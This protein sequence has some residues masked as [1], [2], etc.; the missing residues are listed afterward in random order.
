M[1]KL[2]VIIVSF[3]TKDLIKNCIESVVKNTKG[4]GYE[5]IVVDNGST[6]DSTAE[7]KRLKSKY[8]GVDIRLFE[9]KKNLGFAKANNRGIKKS[10]SDYI[11][12]LNSDTI[13]YDNVLCEIVL[14]VD[15]HP[16]VGVATCALKNPN[17]SLQEA[18]GYFPTLLRVFSWM[19]V[20]DLPLVDKFIKP[21]HPLK[22]RLFYF[23]GDDFFKKERALDWV[24]GAFFLVRKKVVSDVGHLDP[25][26]FM[27]TEDVDYCYRVKT[28]G[29]QI[30]YIPKWSIIHLGGASSNFGYS[31]V[32]EYAGIK[33]FYKKHKPS[34][35]YPILR[36]LLKL[37]A[38]GRRILFTIIEGQ[39]AGK[40]YAE[41]FEIA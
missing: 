13:I 37:G 21:F 9:N 18:G 2:S 30:R 24:K 31:I 35:Q 1:V 41:A 26:Y 23:K 29:W 15:G 5:I 22:S 16:S 33:L 39:E 38:L 27:Y 6:D 4:I 25:D 17:H 34:W 40:I 3:N 20:Q 32:Q 14:W 11:L 12:L 28:K 7:I 10:E 8:R 36:A 19:T